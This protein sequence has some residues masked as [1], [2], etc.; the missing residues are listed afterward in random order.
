[1]SI[2]QEARHTNPPLQ[3]FVSFVVDLLLFLLQVRISSLV[4][5]LTP[6][7]SLKHQHLP[8]VSLCSRCPLW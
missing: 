7:L 4:L 2:R 3:F 5:D 8:S 1:M 6:G